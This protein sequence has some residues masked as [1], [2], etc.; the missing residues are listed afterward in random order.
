MFGRLERYIAAGILRATALTLL[1]LVILLLFFTL[2]DELDQVRR[3]KYEVSDALLVAALT[4]PRYLFEVFPI[5]ALIGCLLGLGGLATRSELIAMRAAGLSLRK[6]VYAVLKIGVLMMLAVALFSEL[7]APPTERFAQEWRAQRLTGQPALAT[8]YGFWARDG[9]AFINIR[10]LGDGRRLEGV[11]IYEF[12]ASDRLRLATQAGA[13][14]YQGAYWLLKDLAQSE[15][16]TDR[17]EVRTLETARWESLLDPDV[18]DAVAL[19][20]TMLPIWELAGY[21]AY[22]RENAQS[23]TDYEVAFWLKV[24]NPVATLAMLVLAVP[25]VVGSPRTT[26]IAQRIFTGAILGAAFFLLTRALSYIAVVY[27]ISPVVT[28]FSPSLLLLFVSVGLLRRI[29]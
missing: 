5:S 14:E 11:R 28:A 22:M 29:R 1:V 27:E 16:L 23:V 26:S 20:P 2:V 6:I 3:G 15:L 9:Q 13:A 7:L 17:I 18:L 10:D 19:R 21:I 12:E 25:L 8:P 4:A 24:V